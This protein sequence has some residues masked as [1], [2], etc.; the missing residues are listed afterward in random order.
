[1]KTFSTAG[2]GVPAA[3][4]LQA[5]PASQRSLMTLVLRKLLA[6]STFAIAGA[7][8]SMST[9]LKGKLAKFSPAASLEDDLSEDYEALDETADETAEEW[10]ED[11]AIEALSDADR[12]ALEREIADLDEFARLATSIDHN[13]KGKALLKALV[14]AF[15]KAREIGAEEKAIIF[16]ESRRTQNYLLRVLADSQFSEG[17]VLFNGSNTDERSKSIYADWLHGIRTPTA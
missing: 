6:S 17:I 14:I 4:N 2:F 3:E 10:T 7:L 12:T 1:M 15:A 13:A 8:A 5:L 11:P 9:R 16:T